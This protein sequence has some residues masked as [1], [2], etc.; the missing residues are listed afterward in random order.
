MLRLQGTR[1]LADINGKIRPSAPPVILVTTIDG[2]TVA[3]AWPPLS[4]N[5]AIPVT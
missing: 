5:V 1:H 4:V 3:G 2:L